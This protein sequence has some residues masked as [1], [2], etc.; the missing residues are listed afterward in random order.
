LGV[1]ERSTGALTDGSFSHLLLATVAGG[2]R[3]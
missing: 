1:V 2:R 3:A